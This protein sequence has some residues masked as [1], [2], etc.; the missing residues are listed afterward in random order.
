VRRLTVTIASLATLTMLAGCQ[1]QRT[2]VLEQTQAG[3]MAA[4]GVGAPAPR[5]PVRAAGAAQCAPP[6]GAG[7]FTPMGKPISGQA[8]PKPPRAL[9]EHVTGCGGVR[10]RIGPDGAP[11]DVEVMAEYPVGYGFGDAVREL[12]E[13]SRW[14]PRDDL[15]WHYLNATIGTPRT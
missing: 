2:I 5:A 10:F 13:T 8:V 1:E 3:S 14:A 11:Q 12:I 6:W 9:A 7:P 15:S 4:S